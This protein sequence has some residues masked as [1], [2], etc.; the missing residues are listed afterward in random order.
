MSDS[1]GGLVNIVII[2]VF[3]VIAMG[4][5]AYNINYMKAFRMK[6][7]IISTYEKYDGV[8]PSNEVGS[9][10]CWDEINSY[11]REIGYSSDFTSADSQ[12][13]GD[14]QVQNGLFAVMK[15]PKKECTKGGAYSLSHEQY[16]Y[17][18][19]TKINLRLPIM[20]KFMHFKF[21]YVQGDTKLIDG[22]PC[23]SATETD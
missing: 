20:D 7:K 9:G 12:V 5:M 19:A 3:I 21:L 22:G 14:Y 17:K 11:A 15:V 2:S 6:D 4:Y 18:V 23:A 1:L 8:C 16:Y 13:L 10:T